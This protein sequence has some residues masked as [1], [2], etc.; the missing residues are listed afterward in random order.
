MLLSDTSG[1]PADQMVKEDVIKFM[2]ALCKTSPKQMEIQAALATDL[3]CRI[4]DC[5]DTKTQTLLTKVLLIVDIPPDGP[6]LEY[7]MELCDEVKDNV[8]TKQVRASIT[9]FEAMLHTKYEKITLNDDAVE[10]PLR[11]EQS[12]DEVESMEDDCSD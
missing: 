7:L 1:H 10:M 8:T 6:F 2:V 5:C 9:K 3:C 12:E 11:D 4:R